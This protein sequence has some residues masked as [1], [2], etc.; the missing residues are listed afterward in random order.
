VVQPGRPVPSVPLAIPSSSTAP[1]LVAP[2]TNPQAPPPNKAF[3]IALFVSNDV[4]S[5]QLQQWFDQHAGLINLKGNC[6]Y[7][8]YTATNPIYKTRFASIVPADQFPVVLFQDAQGG[9]IHAAG[10]TMIPGT[11]DEL[12]SD[13]YHGYQLYLQAKQAQR[14]GAVKTR[15]YSWDEAIS[16]T[17]YLSSQ[18]CPDGFCPTEPNDP[19]RPGDR[20][21]DLLFDREPSGRNA[22][23]WLS[24]GEIATLALFGLAAI[25]LGFILIKRGM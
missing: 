6:E 13:M 12:Y 24:S 21:R 25:L 23:M 8:V 10:R 16:P 15:G 14:T 7:Q 5:A 22:L 2:T 1:T 20:V 3:Q 17:L 18:D 4:R 19:W 11:A 9:H